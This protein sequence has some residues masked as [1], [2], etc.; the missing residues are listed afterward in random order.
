MAEVNP[1]KL[2]VLKAVME[3]IEKDF[4]RGSIMRMSN[5]QVLSLLTSH[6][7]LVVIQRVVLLKFTVQSHLVRPHLPSTLLPRHRSRAVLQHL[8]MPSTPLTA[9]MR[10]DLV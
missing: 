1:E 7:V 6:S 3:K 5:D 8:L 4:G 10:R 2:K 9:T